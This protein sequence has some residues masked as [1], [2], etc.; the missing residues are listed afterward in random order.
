M[1]DSLQRFRRLVGNANGVAACQI[2]LSTFGLSRPPATSM[3]MI[4]VVIVVV[5][6]TRPADVGMSIV[7][8][9]DE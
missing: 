7:A 4:V 8:S 9:L 3:I 5:M 1:P 6:R 2:P